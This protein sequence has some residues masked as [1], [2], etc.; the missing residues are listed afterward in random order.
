MITGILAMGATNNF[1]G[2]NFILGQVQLTH[3][4]FIIQRWQVVL[5][6]VPH[7]CLGRICEPLGAT[8]IGPA[9]QGR[10]HLE[11]GRVCRSYCRHPGS[12]WA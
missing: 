1:I 2:A 12:R 7:R 3:P 8:S 10:D 4:T 6:S 9:E 5:L 11:Y